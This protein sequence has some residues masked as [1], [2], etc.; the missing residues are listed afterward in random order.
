VCTSFSACCRSCETYFGGNGVADDMPE[1]GEGDDI[2]HSIEGY[3]IG[4]SFEGHDIDHSAHLDASANFNQ[5]PDG[6]KCNCYS[7][8]VCVY[9]ICV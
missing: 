8:C 2:D 5:F 7:V 9:V 3:D 4:H 6:A 1:P